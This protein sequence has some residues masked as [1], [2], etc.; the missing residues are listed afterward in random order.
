MRPILRNTGYNIAASVAPILVAMI[1]LPILFRVYGPNR[2]GLLTIAFT[3]T[4]YFALMDLGLA[5]A[6]T[7][8]VARHRS[9]G[10]GPEPRSLFISAALLGVGLS[11]I[12]STILVLLP[13]ALV[14]GWLKVPVELQGE[15]QRIRMI[16]AACLPVVVGSAICR[17]Y[18]EGHQS[19]A[20]AALLRGAGSTSSYLAPLIVLPFTRD[21]SVA[22]AVMLVLRVVWLVIYGAWLFFSL[23]R[24][25]ESSG[26]QTESVLGLARAGCWMTVSNLISPL[27][28][29]LDRFLVAGI[30][31]VAAAGYYATA[32][33]VTNQL[34]MIPGALAGVLFPIFA[35]GAGNRSPASSNLYSKALR[36]TAA[37]LLPL[38]GFLILAGDKL[39]GVWLGADFA[40]NS[41]G[42]L[43]YLS[44]GAFFN[45]LAQ[46]PFCAI[47]GTGRP[48]VTAKIHLI[49]LPA[50]LIAVVFLTV[51][52]GI[53]GTAIAWSL[54]VLVDF[55]ALA[56]CAKKLFGP[57]WSAP[58]MALLISVPALA[59]I[60]LVSMGSSAW[61]RLAVGALVVATIWLVLLSRTERRQLL[62]WTAG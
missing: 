19:F 27:M 44:I 37:L 54:R 25:E 60:Y 24:K 59:V 38:I 8:L 47:Q 16:L 39:F 12:A 62:G 61:L 22:L 4:S 17:G 5:R 53:E 36:M 33:Q 34:V 23:A 41:F 18:L 26:I 57:E 48:D 32:Q 7:H 31:S 55:L 15:A 21:V 14:L 45:G 35:S 30:V 49:E 20:K 2:Y 56:W 43:K 46:V 50:Y 13:G 29:T 51:R 40:R 52:F 3:A 28:A 10:S 9:T 1:T 42:A 6:L 11:S 58:Q